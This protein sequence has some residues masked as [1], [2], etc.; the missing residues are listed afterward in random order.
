MSRALKSRIAPL[1]ALAAAALALALSACHG[2]GDSRTAGGPAAT[3]AP[4]APAD[5]SSPAPDRAGDAGARRAPGPATA[6]PA[7]LCD[8]PGA[9]PEPDGAVL[10][11]FVGRRTR[12]IRECYERALKRDASLRGKVVVRFTI[13]TCGEVS[14]LELTGRRRPA[15]DLAAC[16]TRAVKAW[17]MPFRPSEPVA[18][19]YPF[20]FTAG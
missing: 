1:P 14:D 6:A 16:V 13:G 9:G 18:V 15:P 12:A 5:P 3:A 17:R 2:D 8:R 4:A 19:E 10:R 11:A 7:P 20:N